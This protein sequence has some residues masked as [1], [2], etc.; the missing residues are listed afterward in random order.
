MSENKA[1]PSL[2]DYV[3]NIVI[4]SLM[5]SGTETVLAVLE[6][7]EEKYKKNKHE[8]YMEFLE[9]IENFSVK[10]DD[11]SQAV[12][13]K[14]LILM[15]KTKLLKLEKNITYFFLTMFLKRSKEAKILSSFEEN[16]LRNTLGGEEQEESMNI[17]KDF[18][19]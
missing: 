17:L 9:M 14:L 10:E 6:K 3:K 5:A 12:W 8:M 13:E 11:D 7:L 16:T 4:P 15:Q 19:K 18:S 2:K 1:I